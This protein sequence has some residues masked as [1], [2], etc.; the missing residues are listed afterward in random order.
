M[1]RPGHF[2]TPWRRP[3]VNR[4]IKRL[5]QMITLPIQ[6]LPIQVLFPIGGLL[7]QLL[8]IAGLLPIEVAFH[9]LL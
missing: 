2:R 3:L 8:P 7:T 6:M 4:E 1:S 9:Q 5:L